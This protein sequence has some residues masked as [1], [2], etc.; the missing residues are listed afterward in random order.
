MKAS[1][2]IKWVGT[3]PVKQRT[4][5]LSINASVNPVTALVAPGPEVTKTTP[6]FPVDLA[7]PLPYEQRLVHA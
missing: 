3:C 5:T 7:Y 2:P 1:V 6:T 4:G